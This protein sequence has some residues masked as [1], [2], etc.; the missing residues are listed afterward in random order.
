LENSRLRPSVATPIAFERIERAVIEAKTCR[1][2]DDLGEC[3]N[4][5]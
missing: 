5:L 3:G 1:V 2:D 4:V